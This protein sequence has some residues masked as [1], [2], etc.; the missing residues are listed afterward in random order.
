MA[1]IE[2]KCESLDLTIQ[3]LS[4]HL[5]VSSLLSTYLRCELTFN[6]DD[7]GEKESIT[8]VITQ[9]SYSTSELIPW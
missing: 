9:R 1:Y 8:I 5:L 7:Y 2:L 3:T 6:R 4:S